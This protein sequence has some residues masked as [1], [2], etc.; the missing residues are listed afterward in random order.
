MNYFV[1]TP[2]ILTALGLTLMAW[3]ATRTR[4]N[5]VLTLGGF[6]LIGLGVGARL[7]AGGPIISSIAGVLL[8]FGFGF[9]LAGAVL[10]ARKASAT[11]FV[12]LGITGLALGGA[13]RLF[14][15][16]GGETSQTQPAYEQILIEL[17]PDDHIDEV[18]PLLSKFGA[19]F[20]QAFPTVSLEMD[21]DLAQVFLATIPVS[22][23]R[24]AL[25][26]LRQLLLADSEN[27]DFV[28]LNRAV[29]LTPPPQVDRRS[30]A[31]RGR[32]LANDPLAESQWAI[33]A[34]T[35][36]GAHEI[37]AKAEPS[38]KAIVAILDTGVDARHED[39]TGAFFRSPAADDAHGHG[40]HCAGIAGASTNNSVGMASLNWEGRF[41]EVASYRALSS[42]GMG[43]VESIAQSVIDATADGADVISM[44]LGDY[45][46]KPPRVIKEAIEFAQK[47]DVIV[48]AAAGNSNQDA[49]HHMPAN[50]DGVI[51][52]SAID[53]GM[54]KASFSNTNTTLARPIAA[55]GVDILS[56]VPDGGY[57]RK[58]GT[59]MATPLVAG[60][61]GAMRA[62]QP[63]LTAEEA[64]DIL[65]T[66]G[67][68][69]DDSSLI[70]R[71]IDAEKAVRA[72]T[73]MQPAL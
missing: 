57:E 48:V 73:E 22:S 3:E 34:A 63:T 32:R 26:R 12:I 30:A 51:A 67:R 54:R 49:A 19:R 72:V 53:P 37:L 20:E 2:L 39:I 5:P 7:L 56:L 44:S 31:T 62:L 40:T 4:R 41:I 55:P 38:R 69:V 14:V 59:S 45:S 21:E 66:T 33:D 25:D 6:L 65:S 35:I 10:L 29:Y 15:V 42:S 27:V 52:V 68:E 28:E 71:V 70:G 43:T 36:D 18:A 46:P 61:I 1:S 64:Y 11:A 50:I 8:D 23:D 9:L 24:S 47:R 17:G 60:L 58:S 13:A 16:A